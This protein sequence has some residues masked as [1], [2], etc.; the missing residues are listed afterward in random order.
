MMPASRWMS[1]RSQR[2]FPD[3][4]C[5]HRARARFSRQRWRSGGGFAKPRQDFLAARRPDR[6]HAGVAVRQR[7][8]GRCSRR[9]QTVREGGFENPAV[10]LWSIQVCSANGKARRPG[11]HSCRAARIA[12]APASA[13]RSN[14]ADI[15]LSRASIDRRRGSHASRYHARSPR[16]QRQAGG[17]W[18]N[19]WHVAGRADASGAARECT[20]FGHA[21]RQW[22][23][24]GLL[25]A[26]L[27]LAAAAMLAMVGPVRRS[28]SADPLQALRTE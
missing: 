10:Y 8:G 9:C 4:G 12:I 6:P 5:A 7:A 28:A 13:F 23:A 27:V 1:T 11:S 16:L 18:P 20:Q 26:A 17:A 3:D 24:A 22:R 14:R 15:T 25:G 2:L 19:R 21:G